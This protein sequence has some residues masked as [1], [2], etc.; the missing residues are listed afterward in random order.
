MGVSINGEKYWVQDM[1]SYLEN[2]E[3]VMAGVAEGKMPPDELLE[4]VLPEFGDVWE[5]FFYTVH[6][7]YYEDYNPS[8]GFTSLVARYYGIVDKCGDVSWSPDYTSFAYGAN[9]YDVAE[10]LGIELDDEDEDGE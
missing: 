4:K 3:Q 10:S 7:E 6:N 1:L 2:N 8:Y 5:G 9:A